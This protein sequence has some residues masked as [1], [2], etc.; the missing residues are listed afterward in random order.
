MKIE[1][2]SWWEFQNWVRK[3]VYQ[4]KESNFVVWTRCRLVFYLNREFEWIKSNNDANIER[5]RV[6]IKESKDHAKANQIDALLPKYILHIEKLG[7]TV[8][9]FN[10]NLDE[11]KEKIQEIM[12]EVEWIH[13]K[14]LYSFSKLFV[15]NKKLENDSLDRYQHKVDKQNPNQSKI[16][17]LVNGIIK[18]ISGDKVSNSC[19]EIK[20]EIIEDEDWKK[21]VTT[22]GN[23]DDQWQNK[24]LDQNKVHNE[25][26]V[27][28][29]KAKSVLKYIINL[30]ITAKLWCLL[31]L[32]MLFFI[33]NQWGNFYL[34]AN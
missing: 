3:A 18:L 2:M 8:N 20:K 22:K 17:K 10:S 19:K 34:V 28:N 33:K 11:N 12:L 5:L 1:E 31:I 13:Q 24:E 15:E 32:L 9:Q 7:E 6:I 27:K 26:L 14:Y 21:S 16:S 30:S 25:I 23:Q 29:N 4:E